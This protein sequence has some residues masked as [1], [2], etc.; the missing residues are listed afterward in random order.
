MQ[1]P[2]A[3]CQVFC[4]TVLTLPPPLPLLNPLLLLLLPPNRRIDKPLLDNDGNLLVQFTRVQT[5][6]DNQQM[7]TV[8]MNWV[9]VDVDASS[10]N[11]FAFTPMVVKANSPGQFA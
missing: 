6:G 7:G 11:V 10:R 4:T 9:K 5:F 2:E 8:N 1:H 3:P